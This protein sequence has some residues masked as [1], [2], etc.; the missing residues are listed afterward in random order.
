LGLDEVTGRRIDAG[1]SEQALPV[2]SN[3]NTV[4]SDGFTA[5]GAAARSGHLDVVALL[6]D[7]GALVDFA[8]KGGYIFKMG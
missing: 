6:L 5:L 2:I 7:N 1:F 4:D 3:P 8:N